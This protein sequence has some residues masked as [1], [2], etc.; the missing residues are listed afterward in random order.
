MFVLLDGDLEL[1][2]LLV[3]IDFFFKLDLHLFHSVLQF[4]NFSVFGI[5]AVFESF[6]IVF[7]SVD[8]AF[9]FHDE[10]SSLSFEGDFTGICEL[11]SEIIDLSAMSILHGVD[12]GFELFVL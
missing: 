7:E 10:L 11:D 8:L 5:V 4:F 6:V 9:E 1:A 2:V 3:V 12:L